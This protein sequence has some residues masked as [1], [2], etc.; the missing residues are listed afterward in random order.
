MSES[1]KIKLQALKT[2]TPV[3]FEKFLRAHFFT[4]HLHWQF[5]VSRLQ[6]YLKR[7]SD[8]V[9][10]CEFSKNFKNIFWLYTSGWLLVVLICE[11][12]EVSQKTIFI[13]HL[14]ETKFHVQVAEFQPPDTVK[15]YFID[16]FQV[17][18]TRTISS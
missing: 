14:W 9:V 7:D 5:Q 1:F 10:F 11:F 3:K 4:K 17:F 6:L 18:Y 15:S 16:D 12:W 2:E 8:K 13:E